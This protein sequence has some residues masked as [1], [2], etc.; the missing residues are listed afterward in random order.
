MVPIGYG[1]PVPGQVHHVSRI[2]NSVS[3]Q[4]VELESGSVDGPVVF[5]VRVEQVVPLGGEDGQVLHVSPC[6][7]AATKSE[8]IWS[9]SIGIDISI[10]C[11]YHR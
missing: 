1:G 3:K 2:Q 8:E 6:Q 4:V 9:I 5:S 10:Y 11:T 7:L